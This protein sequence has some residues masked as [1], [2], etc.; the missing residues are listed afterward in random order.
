M[1]G[2]IIIHHKAGA[3][4]IATTCI[5]LAL[6]PLLEIALACTRRA[7]FR[8][9][10]GL[11]NPDLLY[12]GIRIAVGVAWVGWLWIAYHALVGCLRILASDAS[13]AI[14]E[15]YVM[16][17]FQLPGW[18][19]AFLTAETL[20]LLVGG[21]VADRLREQISPHRLGVEK[22]GGVA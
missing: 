12:R 16:Q 10:A 21:A 9:P 3:T 8:V 15:A 18:V 6:V 14:K 2:S 7:L 22:S 5:V 17:M 11:L 13:S 1:P 19:L 4:E 20:A